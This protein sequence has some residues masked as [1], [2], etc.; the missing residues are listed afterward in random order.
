MAAYPSFAPRLSLSE[1]LT[2]EHRLYSM[3]SACVLLDAHVCACRTSHD[4]SL[5]RSQPGGVT[6][7]T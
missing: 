7:D 4:I 5:Q 3:T 6:R 2:C 1:F